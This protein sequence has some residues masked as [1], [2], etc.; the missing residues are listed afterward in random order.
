MRLIEMPSTDQQIATL[1]RRRDALEAAIREL[2]HL[3]QLRD[4]RDSRSH[5]LEFRP[6]IAA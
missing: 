5:V 2:E 1:R 3:R 6:P 4:N